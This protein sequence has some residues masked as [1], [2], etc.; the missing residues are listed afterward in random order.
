M[1]PTYEELRRRGRLVVNAIGPKG[2]L[3]FTFPVDYVGSNG[4]GAIRLWC[5][6]H[7]TETVTPYEEKEC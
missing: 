7:E 1:I 5:I 4:K 6:S 2:E 3:V